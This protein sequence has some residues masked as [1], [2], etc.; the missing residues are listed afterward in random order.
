MNIDIINIFTLPRMMMYYDPDTKYILRRLGKRFDVIKL[1]LF[2]WCP[3]GIDT[4]YTLLLGCA[5]HDYRRI[6]RIKILELHDASVSKM[7]YILSIACERGNIEIIKIIAKKYGG[8]LT[9]TYCDEPIE[10]HYR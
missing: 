10:Y 4:K 6:M 3:Y 9:C 7:N 5:Y 2:I 8:Q 1:R